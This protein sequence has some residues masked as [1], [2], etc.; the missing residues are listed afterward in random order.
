MRVS[1]YWYRIEEE[2]KSEIINTL[3]ASNYSSNMKGDTADGCLIELQ[4]VYRI[5]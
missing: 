3:L 5:S 2:G 1:E 4:Y